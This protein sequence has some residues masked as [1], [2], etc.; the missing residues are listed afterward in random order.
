MT[1]WGF[2]VELPNTVEGLVHV[3]TLQ[4]DYYVFDENTYELTGERT[5]NTYHLG[6]RV[7]V[8]VEN[9]DPLMKTVDFVVTDRLTEARG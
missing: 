5:G 8:R 3:S 6:D 9:A 1:G 2:F 7:R 4:D